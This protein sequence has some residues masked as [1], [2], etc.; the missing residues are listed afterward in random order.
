MDHHT[1][2]M[3]LEDAVPAL[4]PSTV[5]PALAVRRGR[6]IR[7]R[8]SALVGAAAVVVAAAV[9]TPAALAA[10]HPAPTTIDPAAGQRFD[11]LVRTLRVGWTPPGMG[12]GNWSLTGK[13]QFYAVGLGPTS[14]GPQLS[15]LVVAGKQ[16]LPARAF[17]GPVKSEWH[18]ARPV[19]GRPARCAAD[20]GMPDSCAVL[21]WEPAPGLHAVVGYN[22]RGAEKPAAVAQIVRKVAESV[23]LGGSERVRLPFQ[24][25]GASARLRV[26]SVSTTAPPGSASDRWSATVMLTDRPAGPDFKTSVAT[27][28]V[29]DPQA[30][31]E[32]TFAD[33]NGVQLRT[34][35][36]DG[37]RLV[38]VTCRPTVTPAQVRA[39]VTVVAHPDDARNWVPME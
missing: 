17:G 26:D 2:R 39:D 35:S 11:P 25:S 13:S 38:V 23:D 15:V 32:D 9:A 16:T 34:S 7:R 19:G 28:I 30:A 3:L 33:V 10:L 4:P 12:A 6:A 24:L 20:K 27:I 14:T 36:V 8:R 22:A 5:D 29:E 37:S 31:F 21:D 18:A 1:A